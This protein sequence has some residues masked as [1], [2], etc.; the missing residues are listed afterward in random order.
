MRLQLLLAFAIWKLVLIMLCRKNPE[1]IYLFESGP[2]MACDG[3]AAS[4]SARCNN[5]NKATTFHVSRLLVP[6]T[7]GF[8]IF[9]AAFHLDHETKKGLSH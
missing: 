7:E 4:A 1:Y 9:V 2:A 5:I 3:A 6:G 8:W